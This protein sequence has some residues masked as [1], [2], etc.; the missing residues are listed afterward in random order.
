[1][2]GRL[3]EES[4]RRGGLP[5]SRAFTVILCRPNFA[6]SSCFE[7]NHTIAYSTITEPSL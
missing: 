5:T 3:T 2:T 4:A 1:M 6:V 7:L